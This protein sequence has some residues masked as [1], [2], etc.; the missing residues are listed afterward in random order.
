MSNPVQNMSNP[1]QNRATDLHANLFYDKIKSIYSETDVGGNQNSYL[2]M[3]AGGL[4]IDI[5]YFNNNPPATMTNPRGNPGTTIEFNNMASICVDVNG[6]IRDQNVQS[7]YEIIIRS[8]QSTQ[9]VDD[10]KSKKILEKIDKFLFKEKQS[11][12]DEDAPPMKVK[13]QA[14]QDYESAEELNTAAVVAFNAAK[15]AIDFN[16]PQQAQDWQ[17]KA[18]TLMLE[19]TK[20]KRAM[21]SHL[22]VREALLKQRTCAENASEVTIDIAKSSLD[23][24]FILHDGNKVKL[25]YAIPE[26]W[27]ALDDCFTEI[28]ISAK[29]RHENE[30][31]KGTEGSAGLDSGWFFSSPITVGVEGKYKSG[32]KT[33][34]IEVSNIS[35]SFKVA[36]VAIKRL[37]LDPTIF[38]LK[39]WRMKGGIERGQIS[40]GK[41]PLQDDVTGKL[42]P[43]YATAL[44][45][46]KNIKITGEWSSE[47]TR[48]LRTSMEGSSSVGIGPFK[49]SG[50]KFSRSSEE[51]DFRSTV[52][53]GSVKIQ[54]AQIIGVMN[55]IVN[56]SPSD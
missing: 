21:D 28:S 56:H 3:L 13:S 37:W 25:S 45:I 15:K 4:P 46:A 40:S 27:Y 6:L 29:E 51:K 32:E 1:V 19:I 26:R 53:D 30:K 17:S 36:S 50:P 43:Y 12:F 10:E 49:I 2:Q 20:A 38:S 8:A 47:K 54:G 18:P 35:Y 16:D 33:K 52:E 9:E 22:D 11:L 34:L 41:N 7:V 5:G 48:E 23:H 39:N 42:L 44:I 14:Y 55:T 24:D 31:N